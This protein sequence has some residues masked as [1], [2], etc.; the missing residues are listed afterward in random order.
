MNDPVLA[1]SPLLTLSGQNFAQC[2]NEK[3]CPVALINC[4]FLFPKVNTSL[5]VQMWNYDKRRQIHLSV[6]LRYIA[7][8]SSEIIF[9]S[10]Y[11][12]LHFP[13]IPC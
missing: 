9:T 2:R 5:G 13:Q 11:V 6:L 4:I 12:S 1:F 8:I 3:G 7:E 10:L